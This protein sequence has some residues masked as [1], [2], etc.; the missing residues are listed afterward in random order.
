[1][2]AIQ[3]CSQHDAGDQNPVDVLLG[4]DSGGPPPPVALAGSARSSD[5]AVRIILDEMLGRNQSTTHAGASSPC[6]NEVVGP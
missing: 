4:A 6:M 1:M 3:I 5:S 2:E